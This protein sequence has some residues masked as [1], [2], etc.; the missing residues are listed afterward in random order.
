MD[1]FGEKDAFILHGERFEIEKGQR[2]RV[3]WRDGSIYEGTYVGFSEEYPWCNAITM[4]DVTHITESQA[5]TD[6]EIRFYSL[7]KRGIIRVELIEQELSEL[8]DIGP[9]SAGDNFD[10]GMN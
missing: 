4:E 10:A 1:D 8:K 5:I 2:Y 9:K 7:E 6:P 3:L